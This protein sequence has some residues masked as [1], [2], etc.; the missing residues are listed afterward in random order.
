MKPLITAVV[1]L[2]YPWLDKAQPPKKPTDVAKYSAA[3]VF[4]K[5][6]EVA[7]LKAAA[8]D[9]ATE[10]WGATK[11][12]K[13][14]TFGSKGSTFRTDVEDKY[15]DAFAYLTARSESQPG[16]VFLH[17]DPETKKAA[18]V[19]PE[20]IKKV[21]YPGA[22][23]RGLVTPYAYDHPENKGIGWALVGVQKIADASRLDNRVEAEDAFEA[24]MNAV[25]ASLDGLL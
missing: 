14:V 7:E 8:L 19:P 21:F 6:A 23:V 20:L 12:P 13:M 24:D 9:V 2:S 22:K 16:L 3:F 11:G 15:T 1:T 25:P 4:A 10:K 17:A 5:G 18:K